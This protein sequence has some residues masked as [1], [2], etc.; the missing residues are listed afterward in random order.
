METARS[1]TFSHIWHDRRGFTRIEPGEWFGTFAVVL[2]S[3]LIH[4]Q[5]A[6]GLLSPQENL[7]GSGGAA[8]DVQRGEQNE[9]ARAEVV[10]VE[11]VLRAREQDLAKQPRAIAPSLKV[12]DI[13]QQLVMPASIRPKVDRGGFR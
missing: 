3:Q 12:S 10:R 11:H 6:S 13:P 9:A 7:E 1:A 2:R 8:M 5:I 4:R